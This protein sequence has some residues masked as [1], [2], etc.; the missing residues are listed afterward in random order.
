MP[1]IV[2]NSVFRYI[3]VG[4]SSFL[5][6]LIILFILSSIL[7]VGTVTAV[8][9]SFFVG[10]T[11]SFLLQKTF[12][13]SDKAF[14][15]NK[16]A[17][18][19]IYYL[20][21]VGFNYLFT[22]VFVSVFDGFMGVL[23]ARAVALLV[24]TFW[25]YFIYKYYIYTD[26]LNGFNLAQLL[27]SNTFLRVY[28]GIISVI[29]LTMLLVAS[30]FATPVADDYSF[31]NNLHNDR[32][33]LQFGENPNIPESISN[34][35]KEQGGV[36]KAT[37]AQYLAHNGRLATGASVYIAF[38]LFGMN[39][40]K[41]MPVI[42]IILTATLTIGLIYLFASK[43]NRF[44]VSLSLGLF[45][46]F[47]IF[48][49]TPS[50]FDNLF[51]LTSSMV[52]IPSLL[53][54]LVTILLLLLIY[55]KILTNSIV[56][57]ILAP[58]LAVL[59]TFGELG[60]IATLVITCL[61]AAMLLAYKK[62][63]EFKK[64]IIII[65]A[66]IS[67][68]LINLLSPGTTVRQGLLSSDHSLGALI[69][70]TFK[71]LEIFISHVHFSTIIYALAFGVSMYLLLPKKKLKTKHYTKQLI[72]LLVFGLI[73]IVSLAAANAYSMGGWS[74][75][76]NLFIPVI[77][78][79]V[80]MIGIVYLTLGYISAHKHKLLYYVEVAL[81]A[82][83]VL[84]CLA[85]ILPNALSTGTTTIQAMAIRDTFYSQREIEI[86]K[87][88]ASNKQEISIIPLEVL[89]WNS[90]ADDVKPTNIDHQAS[91]V[92]GPLLEFY[93]IPNNVTL[94]IPQP[95]PSYCIE[96]PHIKPQYRCY[97]TLK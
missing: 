46:T 43:K 68:L 51:W 36:I 42:L 58:L 70:N 40:V 29:A 86:K 41:V 90:E 55:K 13:F 12:T 9:I 4:G 92:W 74:S 63:D 23:M 93:D 48:Y 28:I 17:S 56:L 18:Q 26:N 62:F 37:F 79:F 87:S 27:P 7:H 82:L 77:V 89:L 88:L 97:N 49:I 30:Y 84:L 54:I 38:K 11:L 61:V 81:P 15:K 21:L 69:T 32:I 2:N 83:V 44:L 22:L 3:L 72:L 19:A 1:N 34:S 76:R 73:L 60:A 80:L 8:S 50:L 91:W 65:A 57:V 10:L 47:S 66:Q 71:S 16:V 95:D 33:E 20:L 39:A 6:E 14:Q 64:I 35:L 96:S 59:Q 67:G 24:T 85:V 94:I 78:M 75:A 45:F 25:N 31:Y 5:L 52:Y 53:A